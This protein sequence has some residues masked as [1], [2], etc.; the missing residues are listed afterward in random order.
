MTIVKICGITD[1][2]NGLAAIDAGADYLGFIFYP[3]S[4]RMLDPLDGVRLIREL[5]AARPNGWQAV[6]VF[7]N[8]PWDLVDLIRRVCALDVV[9]L[10]GEETP[11]DVRS[12]QAPVIKAVRYREGASGPASSAQ[13]YGA[14]RILLDANVPGRYGG[15]GVAYDWAAVRTAVEHGFLAGGLTPDNVC[16]AIRAA[17]PW[18]VDVSSG[19]ERDGAKDPQLIAQFL[20]AVRD[21]DAEMRGAR[22]T[23]QLESRGLVRT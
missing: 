7:V 13:G 3:P 22:T 9:Q 5:R 21:V 10:N 12:V 18:G 14:E 2:L 20:A 1:L 4:S 19:V 23:N 11:N 15:T 8:E 17:R 6:G 16:D